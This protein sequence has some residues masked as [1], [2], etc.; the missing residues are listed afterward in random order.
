MSREN[1]HVTDCTE[2]ISPLH[3]HVQT[4][5]DDWGDEREG[6]VDLPQTTTYIPVKPASELRD[7]R[8][9][10]SILAEER[11]ACLISSAG[12][13]CDHLHRNR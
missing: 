8:H 13:I 10:L 2:E 1:I 9:S 11:V 12:A 5:G 4:G 3:K 7:Q 6:Y